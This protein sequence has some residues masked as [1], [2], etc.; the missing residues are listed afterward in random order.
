MEK[1]QPEGRCQHPGC[2]CERPATGDYCGE[3]CRNAQKG[4]MDEECHC[5]HP[6]CND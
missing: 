4:G 2:E 5:G 1:Y 6:P 3:Y